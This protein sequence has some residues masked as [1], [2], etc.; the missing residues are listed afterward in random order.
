MSTK[1]VLNIPNT[2]TIARLVSVPF[3][4]H[5]IIHHNHLWAAGLFAAAAAT[6]VLDGYLARALNQQSRLGSFLDPIAE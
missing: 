1:N 5:A 2:L 3:L 6:D 4:A